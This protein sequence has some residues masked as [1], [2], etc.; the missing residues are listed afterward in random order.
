MTISCTYCDTYSCPPPLRRAGT[1]QWS[2]IYD[3][4][5]GPWCFCKDPVPGAE[6]SSQYCAPAMETPEQIN[7]Q[8]KSLPPPTVNVYSSYGLLCLLVVWGLA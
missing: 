5:A 6:N 1:E 7:L 3:S 4:Y 8:C 2:Y